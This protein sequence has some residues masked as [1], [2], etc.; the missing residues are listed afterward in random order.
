VLTANHVVQ[1]AKSIEISLTDRL[2]PRR[3]QKVLAAHVVAND[4]VWD[5]AVLGIG[6]LDLDEAAQL[7]YGKDSKPVV[8]ATLEACGYGPDGRLAHHMGH[9]LGYRAP[10]DE[11]AVTDW[12]AISGR[13]RDGDSGGPVFD[14]KGRVMAVLWGTDL[15]A[16]LGAQAGRLHVLLQTAVATKPDR[17]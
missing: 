15:D 6:S 12:L 10:V 9:F 17:K 13:S 16:M 3:K 14:N 11:N 2:T 1:T 4:V 7:P 8:G 5:V